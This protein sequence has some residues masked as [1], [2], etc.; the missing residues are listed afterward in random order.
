V[1][2]P[3]DPTQ[4]PSGQPQPPPP[5]PPAAPP[6]AQPPA[7]PP[8]QPPAPPPQAAQPVAAP[9][10]GWAVKRGIVRVVVLLFGV[11]YLFYW[12]YKTR[13]KVTGELGT[14]DNVTAQTWGL[15]VPVLNYF[16][17]YWLLRDIA[18]MRMRLGMRA[19]PEPVIMLVI[20]IFVSPV[21]IGLTQQQLNEYW[22]YRSNGY[23]TDAPLTVTEVLVGYAFW[24]A[25]FAIV[26]IVVI[27]AVAVSN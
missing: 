3:T 12:F 11:T 24:I 22:D 15:I 26:I 20:W 7:P 9:I 23:A 18:L 21:G 25:Y 19:E 10:E 27:I 14:R 8:A 17:L 2:A 4:P 5:Q 1:G 6:P 16:I 13:P